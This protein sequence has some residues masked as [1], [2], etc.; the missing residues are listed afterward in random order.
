MAS[1]SRHRRP[2]IRQG[3][4]G[5]AARLAGGQTARWR[6]PAARGNQVMPPATRAERGTALAG[7]A[8][9]VLDAQPPLTSVLRHVD[10]CFGGEVGAGG[11]HAV[12]A[13]TGSSWAGPA[14]CRCVGACTLTAC[15]TCRHLPAGRASPGSRHV[16]AAWLDSR[17]GRNQAAALRA[18]RA[19]PRA[20][21]LPAP[22]HPLQQ[23]A[24][25]PR[26]LT[27]PCPPRDPPHLATCPGPACGAPH[28]AR[29]RRP[30][31]AGV[32]VRHW[33]LAVPPLQCSAARRC[34]SCRPPSAPRMRLQFCLLGGAAL[35]SGS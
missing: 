31:R 1:C 34:C 29:C 23:L 9:P 35:A 30:H 18:G 3:R 33:H 13:C 7:A 16:S 21:P 20:L 5:Q 12:L 17:R 19:P 14:A 2:C 32:P 27:R 28:L 22:A 10:G 25:R 8:G 11:H 6:R 24:C 26:G 15:G 4:A